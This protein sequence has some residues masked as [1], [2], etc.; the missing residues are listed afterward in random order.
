MRTDRY[1]YSELLERASLPPADEHTMDYLYAIVDEGVLGASR[2]VQL[3]QKLF[4][5]LMHTEDNQEVAWQKIKLAGELI[6]DTRGVDTPIIGNSIRWLLR[7]LDGHD[8]D[9][10]LKTLNERTSSWQKE[11]KQRLDKILAVGDAVLGDAPTILAYD[12]SST[13]AAVVKHKHL[14]EPQTTVIVPES[15]A[16]DGGRPYLEE[17]VS[18]GIKVRFVLDMA[19]EH[20]MPDVVAVLLG[21]ESLRCDGSFLNTIGSRTVARTAKLLA[22]PTYACTDLYK[23]DLR[24]YQGHMKTPSL[25]S[26]HERLLSHS[27]V[28][29]EEE[30][31]TDAPE[32]EVIGPELHT[33]FLTEY[34]LV[35]PQSIWSLGRSVFPEIT[36]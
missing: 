8:S 27:S 2:H 6:A 34:G 26:Y 9:H 3:T 14:R 35:P 10:V 20:V 25:R 13:V 18:A 21:V 36:A 19:I 30:V 22:V 7:D 17:F 32:L 16:I 33:G 29:S 4:L 24:S 23:L 1:R 5:H 12:Y 11:S 31:T 15:R 28:A